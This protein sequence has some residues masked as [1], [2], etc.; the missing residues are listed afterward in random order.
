MTT[1]KIWKKVGILIVCLVWILLTSYKFTPINS[2]G[3][4]LSY[5]SGLLSIPTEEK[6]Q[7]KIPR[8]ANVEIFVDTIGIPHIYANDEKGLA[9]G[10]G[11]MHAK[12]RYF[13]MELTTRMVLGELSEVFGAKTFGSDS[14]WKPYQ[15]QKKA[16]ELLNEYKITNK[17]VYDYI[18]SY[19]KGINNYL[20]QN[21]LNDPLYKIFDTTPRKWKPEYCLLISWYLSKNLTYHDFDKEQQEV[22]DKLPEEI[23]DV[24]FPLHPEN[25]ITILPQSARYK[26]QSERNKTITKKYSITKKVTIKDDI[27]SN[28]WVIHKT[29][30]KNKYAIIAN[31]PHLFLTLPNTFYEA[32]LVSNDRKLYGYTVPGSPLIV[33]GHND[34]VSWGVTNGSWDLIDRY[35]LK[36]KEDSLYL[37]DGKWI[38]FKKKYYQISI[39]GKQPKRI[40]EQFT[41]HGKVIKEDSI[42]YAQKW[43]PSEKSYSFRSIYNVNK[44]KNWYTFKEALREYDYPPQNFVFSDTNDTIGIVCAGQSMTNN[45]FY[46]GGLLDGV[47]KIKNNVKLDTLW[48]NVNPEKGYL[49]SANQQPIQNDYY[50]GYYWFKNDY[51]VRRINSLLKNNSSWD[52]TTSMK[53]Q[54]DNVDVAYKEYIELTKNYTILNSYQY[55]IDGLSQWNG[56]ISSEQQFS[57]TYKILKEATNIEIENYTINKLGVQQI[58]SLRCFLEYLNNENKLSAEQNLKKTIVNTIFKKTDSILNIEKRGV[59]DDF[60]IIPNISFLPGFGK[61]VT[62][63]EGNNNTINLNSKA[64]SSFRSVFQ[65]EEGNIIGFSVIAGGQSG[66]INSKHYLDQLESWKKGVYHQTQFVNN[67]KELKKIAYK[68]NL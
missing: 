19:A 48:K 29:K 3:E 11:Y 63:I 18:I 44:S 14:F 61:K 52:L 8:L 22:F 9:Y 33:S 12:D 28:N 53:M 46:K 4:L 1:L 45:L 20:D 64:H 59:S 35:L 25:L 26:V 27:G 13:Q 10:L 6:N 58:S 67:P 23:I 30:T 60:L 68:I 32:H 36:V 15:F 34:Q 42:Y 57:K 17:E 47:K 54:M 16:V 51:R 43:Y 65:M 56:E 2:I 62:G 31:D 5:K 24:F 49:F 66:K 55:I 38:P 37:Y 41:I 7:I 39:K 40:T 21:E 50:F